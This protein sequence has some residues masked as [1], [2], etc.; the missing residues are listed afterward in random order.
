MRSVLFLIFELLLLGFAGA[1]RSETVVIDVPRNVDVTNAS[2]LSAELKFPENAAAPVAAVVILHSAGGID[3]SSSSYIPALNQAGFATL[4][5][6]MFVR[7]GA[8][9]FKDA[10]P[11]AYSG[12]A[13]LAHEPRI[14]PARIAILG[15]SYGGVLAILTASAEQTKTYAPTA[16]SFAAHVSFYP[17]CWIHAALSTGTTDLRSDHTNRYLRGISATDYQRMTGAPVLLLA[18]EK[19]QYDDPDSCTLFVNG[20]PAEARSLYTVVLRAVVS[21]S[22]ETRTSRRN[23]EKRCLDI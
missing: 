7:G 20:L 11:Y 9:P 14:D 6:K 21:A 12:L 1:S 19:D 10:L 15:F 4:E 3:A 23:R 17:I 5:V 2:T 18:A 22:S 16:R 13:Y 8:I